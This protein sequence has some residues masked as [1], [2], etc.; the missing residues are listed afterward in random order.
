MDGHP[1]VCKFV[2]L[3]RTCMIG[4]LLLTSGHVLLNFVK[5]VIK[6]IRLHVYSDAMKL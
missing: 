4:S 5:I 3:I 2:V 1:L 6:K